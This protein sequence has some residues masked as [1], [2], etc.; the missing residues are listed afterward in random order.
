MPDSAT[1]DVQ[2]PGPGGRL[3]VRAKGLGM[4]AT[5]VAVLVHGANLSGQTAFDFAFPNGLRY[6]LMDELV[7]QG[8]AAVTF[9]VRGYGASEL[10]GDPLAVTTEAAIDDLRAV[11][12]WLFAESA[13]R[14]VHLLGWSWGGRIAARF[15]EQSPERV[16][17][18]V[19]Y[20]PALGGDTARSPQPPD[21]AWQVNTYEW[22]IGRLEPDLT[23]PDARHAFGEGVAEQEP[24]SPERHPGRGCARRHPS[25]PARHQAPDR[26]GVRR[27]HQRT[28]RS[29]DRDRLFRKPRDG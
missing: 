6:S 17:R 1:I 19:L 22:A 12:D 3:A 9:G 20:D 18:L 2:V 11:V 25:Q 21:T 23:E 13:V 28:A 24:R 15:T 8:I 26:A 27:G 14:R 7:A 5:A 16:L 10:T 4:G 29:P